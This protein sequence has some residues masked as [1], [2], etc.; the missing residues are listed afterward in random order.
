LLSKDQAK[1]SLLKQLTASSSFLNGKVDMTGN[2]IAMQSFARS[3]NTFLRRYLE[4]ITGVYTGADMNI[5]E[6][7]F[8]A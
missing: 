8:E 6:T 2:R 1:Y 5:K 3:G 7:F 4:Q